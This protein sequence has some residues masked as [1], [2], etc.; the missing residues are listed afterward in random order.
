[1]LLQK[2]NAASQTLR[3]KAVEFYIVFKNNDI[4]RTG[5]QPFTQAQHVGLVDAHLHIERMTFT[6]YELNPI[7]QAYFRKFFARRLAAIF[8]F[9]QRNAV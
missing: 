1:M 4:S 9:L 6:N 8:T 3:I 2:F 5:L 7:G